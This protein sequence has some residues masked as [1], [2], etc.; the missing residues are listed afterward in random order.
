MEL[1][2]DQELLKEIKEKIVEDSEMQGVIMK[3]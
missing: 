1:Q 2:V 3:L